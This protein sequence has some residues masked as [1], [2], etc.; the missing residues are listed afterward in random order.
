MEKEPAYNRP[1]SEPIDIDD[2]ESA[3]EFI[4]EQM[5]INGTLP[6]ITVP[7]E[8]ADSA[9]KGIIPHTTWIYDAIIAGM[10]GREPYLPE[11]DS[12][13]V[14]FRIKAK[15]DDVAPRFTGPDKHFHGVVIFKKP[16]SPDL[17]EELSA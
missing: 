11:N 7:V 13:R 1:E 2:I 14:T 16:I 17:L 15:P 5:E 3:R 9:R 12:P 6:T 8:Y 4:R 10:L